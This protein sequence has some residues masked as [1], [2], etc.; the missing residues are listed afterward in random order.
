MQHFIKQDGYR[1][2][3]FAI[4]LTALTA[5]TSTVPSSQTDQAAQ[6][7]SSDRA[8]SATQPQPTQKSGTEK[9]PSVQEAAA[10]PSSSFEPIEVY[11][12][13]NG[14][15]TTRR[16]TS[17]AQA[18]IEQAFEEDK[19][20]IQKNTTFDCKSSSEGLTIVGTAEG[21]FT[22]LNASQQVFLYERCRS[23]RSF[24][25][26]GLVVLDGTKVAAHYVYGENGLMSSI[27]TTPDVNQNG[28]TEIVLIGGSTNQGYTGQG[29]SLLELD[30][31]KL[32]HLGGIS[33]YTDNSGAAMDRS[34][35]KTTA[36]KISAQPGT[37]PTF[38]KD[39][40][41]KK[42]GSQVW[43]LLQE[44]EPVSLD[45]IEPSKFVKVR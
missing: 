38:L 23:G 31:G 42:G 7:T 30:A 10:Q 35:V 32:S 27:T 2:S 37:N 12:G 15:T 19:A 44:A 17:V 25:L 16:S 11:D 20:A 40:Y 26:G 39:T 18:A 28:L 13:R 6:P 21:T 45:Q 33:T 1:L 9:A 22:R 34:Q 14:E 29:I 4:A 8:A 36:Y 41:E 5:C 24:G 43:S 3:G